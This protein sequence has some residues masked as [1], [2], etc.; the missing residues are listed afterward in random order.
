MRVANAS[1]A[2]A[3]STASGLGGSAAATAGMTA[4]ISADASDRKILV[5]SRES[6]SLEELTT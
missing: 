4:R 6:G 2:R 1:W 5:A 3:S